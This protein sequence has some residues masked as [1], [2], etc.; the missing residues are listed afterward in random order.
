MTDPVAALMTA[1]Q[2]R[3]R[4]RV[5]S[6]V[7]TAFGDA[8]LPR[9][10]RVAAA[11]LGVLFDRMG[12]EPGTLRTALS[13]LSSD[14]W[15]TRERQGRNAF[16]QLSDPGQA[17]FGPA[18][19]VIYAPVRPALSE[20]TFTMGVEGADLPGIPVGPGILWPAGQA[21]GGSDHFAMTGRI[22]H[23]P[24]ALRAAT[25]SAEHTGLVTA[26]LDD[27]ADL[28]TSAMDGLTAMA[29]RT[30]LIHQWRR[31]ALRFADIPEQLAPEGWPGIGVRGVVARIYGELLPA[32]E[33]WLDR[34]CYGV[35]TGMPPVR[36]GLSRF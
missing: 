32:S 34:P 23:F 36:D 27:F 25:V 22:D 30:L 28:D 15:I 21:P 5:W 7:I 6:L 8:V 2:R 17:E 13:R 14:G 10:G 9:G 12:V 33:N 19:Q 1:M 31:I 24:P 20:W 11:R 35:P 3:E 4:L 29:V 16:Y 26:L 18:T